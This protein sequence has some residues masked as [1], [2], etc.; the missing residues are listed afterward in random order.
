VLIVLLSVDDLLTHTLKLFRDQANINC[1]RGKQTRGTRGG[2][3]GEHTNKAKTEA[4]RRCS[5]RLLNKKSIEMSA[6]SNS[7]LWGPGEGRADVFSSRRAVA[8]HGAPLGS[9]GKGESIIDS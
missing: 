1:R 9:R 7:M 4:D 5:L 2:L 8:D 6:K 3:Q